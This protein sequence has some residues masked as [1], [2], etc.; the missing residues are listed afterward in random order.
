MA[1]SKADAEKSLRAAF[2]AI[3]TDHSGSIEGKE[4]EA[5]LV[6]YHKSKG[7][8]QDSAKLKKEVQSF[9]NDCDKNHDNK[10]SVDEFLKYFMQFNQ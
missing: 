4:V 7:K 10:V 3:D 5:V 8:P 9:L 2:N 6:A 1:C